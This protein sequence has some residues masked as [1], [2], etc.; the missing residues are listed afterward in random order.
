MGIKKTSEYLKTYAS[1]AWV[2]VKG[3]ASAVAE[4]TA[5]LTERPS[6]TQLDAMIKSRDAIIVGLRSENADLRSTIA[7]LESDLAEAKKAPAKKTPAKKT[8]KKA[9]AKK[10]PAAK[11]EPSKDNK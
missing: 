5:A 3:T 1:S 7:K 6:N 10:A 9:P 8:A 11:T 4:Y 2:G